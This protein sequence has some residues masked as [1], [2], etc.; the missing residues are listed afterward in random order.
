MRKVRI[1]APTSLIMLAR[2]ASGAQGKTRI[3]SCRYRSMG[4]TQPGI[5]PAT[6]AR[7][8]RS[9]GWGQ[10]LSLGSQRQ[11]HH[12]VGAD[13]AGQRRAAH[14]LLLELRKA[15]RLFRGSRAVAA[16]D[17]GACV[18]T[19]R[20]IARRVAIGGS[21]RCVAAVHWPSTVTLRHWLDCTVA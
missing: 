15:S 13:R 17:C 3:W 12:V 18:F 1:L 8:Y 5:A 21:L 4:M 16:I 20:P 14:N 7:P 19:V 2:V 6:V 10:R 9:W 11:K